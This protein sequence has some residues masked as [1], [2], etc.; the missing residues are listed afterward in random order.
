M[1][2]THVWVVTRPCS[3]ASLKQICSRY[4]PYEGLNLAN[5]IS[6]K[7][8]IFDRKLDENHSIFHCYSDIYIRNKV[9]ILRFSIFSQSN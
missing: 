4:T 2:R 3:G 1:T 8:G 7:L 9:V 5:Q 6:R